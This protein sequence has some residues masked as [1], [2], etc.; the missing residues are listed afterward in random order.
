MQ[1]YT[2]RA[3]ICL[4]NFRRSS[5]SLMN[6]HSFFIAL[7]VQKNK[8]MNKKSTKIWKVVEVLVSIIM[9]LGGIQHFIAPDFYLPFVPDFLVFKLTIIYLSGIL[10]IVLGV[11]LYIKKYKSLATLGIFLL[12]IVF[13]PVHIWDVFSN[14]PAIGSHTAALIRLPIQL[15]L[16][17][18][19]WKLK[20]YCSKNQAHA[21]KK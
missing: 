18:I 14:T 3:R 13:L 19:T 1:V 7:Q 21:S 11:S 4:L 20:Q 9:I 15:A 6:V 17:A 5:R 8:D 2:L 12:M 16:I 10:E